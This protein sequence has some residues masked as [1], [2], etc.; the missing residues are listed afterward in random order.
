M[1]R[2]RP[3]SVK[4][5]RWQQAISGIAGI[6]A[7][8]LVSCL[9]LTQAAWTEVISARI[10][11]TRAS[12]GT[13]FPFKIGERLTYE[14]SW[15]G[16]TA[17]LAELTIKARTRYNGR[18]VYHLTS[19][20]T[21][22][23]MVGKFY[24]VDDRIEAFVDVQGLYPY[25]AFLRQREGKRK[26]DKDVHFDQDRHQVTY[27]TN[28]GRPRTLPVPPA[29][30]DILSSVYYLRTKELD[31]GGT[32]PLSVFSSKRNYAVE[33][34]VLRK[35][36][37]ETFSGLLET[38]VVKPHVTPS[39]E[40]QKQDSLIWVTADERKLPVKIKTKVR[41]GYIEATLIQYVEQS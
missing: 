24:T 3:Q 20:V 31:V 36:A 21:S 40:S 9:Y 28:G 41:L 38:Y 11:P 10:S 8:G 33:V 22:A 26:K 15:Q 37:V 14:V 34:K 39:K 2:S 6:L 35:E 5:P 18:E 17:G 19:R 29:V 25:Y 4:H 27:T 13:A 7:F 16:I 1:K 30:K 32:V 12:N 23:G